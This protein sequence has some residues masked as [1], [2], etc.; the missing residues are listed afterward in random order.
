M[1][2][3]IFTGV[4][5]ESDVKDMDKHQST[6]SAI[7]KTPFTNVMMQIMN[8]YSYER[9]T[10]EQVKR[11]MI[12]VHAE[13]AQRVFKM[14]DNKRPLIPVLCTLVAVLAITVIAAY[15]FDI[16]T[17]Q[18][19]SSIIGTYVEIQ[20]SQIP[21]AGIMP[22]ETY[23]VKLVNELNSDII[24][25]SGYI[26]DIIPD[27]TWTIFAMRDGEMVEVGSLIVENGNMELVQ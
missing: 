10:D 4:K 20:D 27:G 15:Q 12:P 13:I 19:Q 18:P 5:N 3:D 21:L 14:R 22:G 26:P 2:F 17:V 25:I 1:S 8:E 11:V 23:M 24:E 9:I 6:I 16:V 7:P